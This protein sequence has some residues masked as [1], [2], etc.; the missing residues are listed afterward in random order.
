MEDVVM[1]SIRT[2]EKG[3][4]LF[5]DFR[6]RGKRCREFT[7]LKD[8]ATNRRRLQAIMDRIDYEI[9]LDTF[10]Y[11]EYFPDSRNLAKFTTASVEQAEAENSGDLFKIFCWQ[12]FEENMVRWKDSYIEVTRCNLE[13]YLIP[14]FGDQAVGSITRASILKFR[15]ALA[16]VCSETGE[17]LLSND[18]IN[19]IMTPLRMIL[20]EASERFEFNTPFKNIK[21]LKVEPTDVH[22]FSLEEV[23]LILSKVR[24]DFRD[25][26]L[27]RFFTGMRT[28]EVDGLQWRYVD[29]ENRQILI[30]K[31]L[32]QRKVTDTKTV[33]S[34]RVIEM[35]SPVVEAFQ[36][37][38]ERAAP[39]SQFVFTNTVGKPLCHNNL[40]KRIWYPLLD[41]LGLERR[42]PYQTR[43]TAATL[44]LA[45]GENPEW[46]ARQMGHST[47]RM[48]FTVYSRYVPN[49]TRQ[50]G[51]AMDR[52]LA[53]KGFADE[54]VSPV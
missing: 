50:D 21:P 8:N 41:D 53:A 11:A 46:I 48:L 35:S 20:E 3:G 1:G 29:I 33:G 32:V 39:N 5:F 15:A 45:A 19:H 22:P 37:L 34:R 17:R 44:W 28:S 31:T 10:N 25:Y 47:T 12:W 2:K 9:A 16:K 14:E 54:V 52:L 49:L 7:L 38:K 18:R 4:S 24:T 13:K 26:F 27:I 23:H 43:H 51:S 40:R 36:R 42:N 6:Y 30:R